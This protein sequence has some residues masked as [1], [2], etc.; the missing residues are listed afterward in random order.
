MNSDSLLNSSDSNTI[1]Y[2]LMYFGDAMNV[3]QPDGTLTPENDAILCVMDVI[4]TSAGEGKYGAGFFTA[5]YAVNPHIIAEELG[6]NQL[7]Q[8][9][10]QLCTQP[11]P[12]CHA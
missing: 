1:K 9:S 8:Y 6:H 5:H 4:V 3:L 10:K 7:Q 2:F 12:H 11:W